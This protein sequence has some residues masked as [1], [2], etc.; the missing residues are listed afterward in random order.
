VTV[1]GPL[2]GIQRDNLDVAVLKLGLGPTYAPGASIDAIFNFEDEGS[3]KD[4]TMG[5]VVSV[6][7]SPRHDATDG[8]VLL[9]CMITPRENVPAKSVASQKP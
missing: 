2:V 9:R 3:L 1:V 4:L 7:G 5:E 6:I 8:L